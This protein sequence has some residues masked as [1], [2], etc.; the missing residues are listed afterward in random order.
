MW[1][2]GILGEYPGPKREE[3]REPLQL[4]MAGQLLLRQFKCVTVSVI[5]GKYY[6]LLCQHYEINSKT[7]V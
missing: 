7:L 4:H 5:V 1:E 2:S 6:P 3:R